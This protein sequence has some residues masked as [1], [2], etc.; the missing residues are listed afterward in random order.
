MTDATQAGSCFLLA[1]FLCLKRLI[2]FYGFHIFLRS[3]THEFFTGYE[4]F[5]K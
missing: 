2:L 1:G 4:E 3:K 5:E